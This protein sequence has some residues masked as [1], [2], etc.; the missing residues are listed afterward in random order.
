MSKENMSRGGATRVALT[1][2]IVV[3][4]ALLA[5][6]LMLQSLGET[7]GCLTTLAFGLLLLFLA[8]SRWTFFGV[9]VPVM[10]A[11]ALYGA[12]GR[13]YG[14]PSYQYLMS[15]LATDPAETA[16]FLSL[17]SWKT[18]GLVLLLHV[19]VAAFYG[20]F[21]KS[22]LQPC[23]SKALVL[24]T[25]L[26]L[27]AAE[28]PTA[29]VTR[30]QEALCDT[31]KE[32]SLL[33]QMA[34]R[35]A[36]LADGLKPADVRYKNYVLVLGESARRDYL[37]A[38][39]YPVANTP[40]LDAVK[41]TVVEGMTSAG[42]NTVASLRVMLTHGKVGD[43]P[44]YSRTVTGLAK[45]G[46]FATYWLSNQGFTGEFDTPI[47]AV[48]ALA[49]KSIFVRTGSYK[50]GA[51]PDELLLP[52]LAGVLQDGAARPR[53]IVLHIMGSHTDACR[54][55]AG[56][57]AKTTTDARHQQVACYSDSIAQTDRFLE[58]VYRQLKATGDSFSLVYTS[59]HGLVLNESDGRLR[60]DNTA[61]SRRHCDVPLVRMNSDD[62]AHRRVKSVKLGVRFTDG[63]GRWLGLAGGA[64]TGYDLFDG[65]P[66]T[67]TEN[68]AAQGKDDPPVDIRPFV[69]GR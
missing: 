65:V 36:W 45:A 43:F 50:Q 33:S 52:P 32:Q 40:F 18:W 58:N 28:R 8:S 30:L 26:C 38:Y 11:A 15:L 48:S 41:G 61:L 6:T 4:L 67:A 27:I 68:P 1:Q 34:R 51:F 62:E 56:W 5:A 20:L 25:M 3:A 21:R 29:F 64:L 57:S 42:K 2:A 47:T 49:H 7:A 59:D 60:L 69:A 54:R 14:L 31:Q 10:A 37:H 39:G 66:D 19:T 22:G 46:G 17:I 13:E 53:F 16:E 24:W 9:A 44:D 55:I 63:I 12:V 35:N 23:R